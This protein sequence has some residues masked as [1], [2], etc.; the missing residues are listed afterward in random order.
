MRDSNSHDFSPHFECG[1]STNSA[2][3]PDCYYRIIVDPASLHKLALIYSLGSIINRV[4]GGTPINNPRKT[5][6]ITWKVLNNS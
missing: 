5:S 3:R 1:A 2:N 4:I 6:L